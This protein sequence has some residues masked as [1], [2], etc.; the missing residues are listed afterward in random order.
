VRDSEYAREVSALAPGS[1][2]LYCG[3]DPEA[4]A[5]KLDA[6]VASPVSTLGPGVPEALRPERIAFRWTEIAGGA[7]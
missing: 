4:L 2:E 1:V 6:A 3:T 7:P 5:A